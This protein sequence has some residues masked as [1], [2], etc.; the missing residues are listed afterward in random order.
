VQFRI[1]Q[2]NDVKVLASRE[3]VQRGR[4]VWR[5]KMYGEQLGSLSW[6]SPEQRS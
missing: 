3:G 2:Y 6:V 1:A 4:R 5:D